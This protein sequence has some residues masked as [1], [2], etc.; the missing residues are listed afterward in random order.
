MS[1]DPG[2]RLYD[3][4]CDLLLAAQELRRASYC[5]ETAEAIPA[6]LG[7]VG[8]AIEEVAAAA[9]GLAEELRRTRTLSDRQGTAA[10]QALDRV[11]EQL[12]AAARKCNLAREL[13]ATAT[14]PRNTAADGRAARPGGARGERLADLDRAAGA[15]AHGAGAPDGLGP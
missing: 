14:W 11:S 12:I 15:H 4:A 6:T 1:L 5:P 2:N 8:S 9:G 13:S 7:C 10:M 3:S